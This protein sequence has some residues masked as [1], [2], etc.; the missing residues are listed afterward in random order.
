M[1]MKSEY[2]KRVSP[3]VR[4]GGRPRLSHNPVTKTQKT[5]TATPLQTSEDLLTRGLRQA[6][7]APSR[8]G[9]RVRMTKMG[10]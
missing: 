4:S 6:R 9:N 2:H 5:I 7:T 8:A 1:S 10:K 3:N